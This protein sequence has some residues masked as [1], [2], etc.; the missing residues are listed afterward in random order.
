MLYFLVAFVAFSAFK[1]WNPM[2]GPQAAI[3][4]SDDSSPS[5]YPHHCY[6]HTQTCTTYDTFHSLDLTLDDNS[7]RSVSHLHYIAAAAH[8]T[9]NPGCTS[10]NLGC[11]TH[12]PGLTAHSPGHMTCNH[13]HMT[14]NPDLTTHNPSV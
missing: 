13:S 14:H 3:H 6:H 2:F 12:N 9:D 8:K 5:T 11:M 4:Y 7:L 10:H 1:Q